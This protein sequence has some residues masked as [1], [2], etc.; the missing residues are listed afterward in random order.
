MDPGLKQQLRLGN[1]RRVNE[2][3]RRHSAGSHQG[4]SRVL[5]QDSQIELQDIVEESATA[6]AKEE[7]THS[8]SARNVGA[9]AIFGS[10]TRTNR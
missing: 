9:P 8:W 5:H 4:S 3:L 6:Q 1:K 2:T 7:A 10:F